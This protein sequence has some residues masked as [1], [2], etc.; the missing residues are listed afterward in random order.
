VCGVCCVLCGVCVCVCVCGVWCVCCVL[1]GMCVCCVLCSS[2][3]LPLVFFL[4][5]SSFGVLPLVF[6]LWCF[7]FGVLHTVYSSRF[8]ALFSKF[9]TAA[10]T[11]AT[12]GGGAVCFHKVNPLYFDQNHPHVKVR[13]VFMIHVGGTRC[14]TSSTG[15]MMNIHAGTTLTVECTRTCIFICL[16]H[17][18]YNDEYDQYSRF[19]SDCTGAPPR[20]Y[21]VRLPFVSLC[22]HRLRECAT[23]DRRGRCEDDVR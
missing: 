21:D 3:V 2:G 8:R 19:F 12:A 5:C 9:N 11:P 15:S 1:C 17:V 23:V 22:T 16:L 6:F 7:S 20:K 4:W 14:V 13:E 10:T 18:K